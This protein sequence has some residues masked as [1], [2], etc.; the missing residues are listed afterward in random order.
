M[1]GHVTALQISETEVAA[2]SAYV[3]TTGLHALPLL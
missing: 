2:F 3:M 1:E